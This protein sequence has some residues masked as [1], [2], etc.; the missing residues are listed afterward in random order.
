MNPSL[1]FAEMAFA[2]GLAKNGIGPFSIRPKISFI[3]SIGCSDPSA[4]CS[5]YV[6]RSRSGVPAAG[7]RRP[8]P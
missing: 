4:K 5:Q 3:S 7:I 1:T 6:Y 2:I 8:L